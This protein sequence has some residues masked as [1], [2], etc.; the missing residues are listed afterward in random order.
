MALLV[1]KKQDVLEKLLRYQRV[2][3]IK[4]KCVSNSVFYHDCIDQLSPNQFSPVCGILELKNTKYTDGNIVLE[5]SGVALVAHVW[6]KEISTG[7][8]IECSHE[9][10]TIKRENRRY[11]TYLDLAKEADKETS[12]HMLKMVCA[13]NT[14]LNNIMRRPNASTPYYK[15]LRTYFLHTSKESFESKIIGKSLSVR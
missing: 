10:D 4:G 5:A 2:N 13:L 12:V 1:R 3:N 9:F 6:I 14:I 8:V 7:N 15:D 11:L